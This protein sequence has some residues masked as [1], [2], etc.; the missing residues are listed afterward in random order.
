MSPSRRPPSTTRQRWQPR[1]CRRLGHALQLIRCVPPRCRHPASS[2]LTSTRQCPMLRELHA[3]PAKG[4]KKWK[5]DPLIARGCH[6]SGRV[7]RAQPLRRRVAAARCCCRDTA[8]QGRQR[9]AARGACVVASSTRSE[10]AS[11]RLPSAARGACA[12]RSGVQDAADGRHHLHQ[13]RR[14]GTGRGDGHPLSSWDQDVADA[15]RHYG[16]RT[17]TSRG[18]V[19]WAL[20]RARRWAPSH[21]AAAP[22]VARGTRP[23]AGQPGLTPAATT[24]HHNGHLVEWLPTAATTAPQPARS[25]TGPRSTSCTGLASC[26]RSPA[27]SHDRRQQHQEGRRSHYH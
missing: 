6:P 24:G 2:Y 27:P 3:G 1:C 25:R 22:A 16:G 9:D 19:G 5:W 21:T 17:S 12:R 15:R 13:G 10:C 18:L 26:T 20:N 14:L 4:R 7:L 8:R 11:M 23:A